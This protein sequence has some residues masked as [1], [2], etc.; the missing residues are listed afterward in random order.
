MTATATSPATPTLAPPASADEMPVDFASYV[1][2][3]ASGLHHLHLMVEGVHCGGCIR[4]IEGTL[5]RLAGV[6]SARLNMSTRRLAVAWRGEAP[7]AGEMAAVVTGQGYRVVPFDPGRLSASDAR[8]ET[9]LLRCLAVAGFAAANVMLFSVSVWA[10]HAQGMG[11]AT[12]GLLHWFSALIAMPAI[13]YAGRPFFGSALTALR[14]G[15]TNMDV[16]ISIGVVLA[17]AMSLFETIQGGRHAYFDSAVSLLF[18]LLI[19][20]YL[21]SR[22]RGRARSAA[23]RLLTLRAA[24]VTVLDAEGRRAMRPV[25]QVRPGMTVLVAAGERVGVDGRVVAG[26]STLD[27]SL[28]T[29]ETLPARAAEGDHVFAGTLNLEGPLRLEALAVG[30]DTALAE[31]VR[32][33]ELSEQCRGRHVGIADRVARLYAPVVHG[34]ALATFLGW[35]LG[36]GAAWQTALLHAVAVLIIT[37]PCALGLAVPAVQVIASGRLMC[38]GVLLKSPTALERLAQIDTVVLDKTGTLTEGRPVLVDPGAISPEALAVAA[39]LA[40]ASR[41]PLARAVCRATPDV[42]VA[43]SVQEVPGCGL[44][45]ATPDGEVRLGRRGWASEINDDG[46]AAP[47]LWLSRPGHELVRF[48]FED[49][50]RADAAAVVTALAARGL[51]V[52]LLSGDREGGVAEAARRLGIRHWRAG[53]TP[54]AKCAHLRGLVAS[55][56]K[57]LMIGDGLN[58]APA[59]AAA[60]V[61]LSPATA[62]DISQTTADA[63]FQGRLLTPVLDLL[64]VAQRADGLVRQNFALAFAYNLVTVPLAIAGLVTPLIAAASMSTSSI[65][66]V[67]NALRLAGGRQR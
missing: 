14:A 1:R 21:D 31:I 26:I 28:I 25:E 10:G 3:D 17:T 22:A 39:G 16:P 27:V 12:R 67:G 8:R 4:R 32:L 11:P 40:G 44:A 59:L 42:P 37:C 62:L 46:S 64:D 53:V 35:T 20:R 47:E 61:S 33:M 29:G 48:A 45:L 58:D 34:L 38:R 55:G 66:V 60:T 41:H 43:Q 56:R 18:F 15:R 13:A 30:E 50:L 7:R 54:A 52:E 9:E 57:V 36:A 5:T 2:T 6:E 63:V 24:A 49:P 51:A 19:G 23:E 65:F